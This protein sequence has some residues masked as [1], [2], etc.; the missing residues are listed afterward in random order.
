MEKRSSQ[1][2]LIGLKTEILYGGK[3][4]AGAIENLSN[5]GLITF[6]TTSKVEFKSG[7]IFKL[8][9]QSISGEMLNLN[10]KVR[11]SSQIS[12]NGLMNRVGVEI[13]GPHMLIE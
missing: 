13:S 11:W 5:D 10:C 12:P 6:S 8:K 3:S 1:R 2:L 7:S 9:L 4:Y